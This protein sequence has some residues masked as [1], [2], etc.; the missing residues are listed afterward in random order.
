MRLRI[1]PFLG[2]LGAVFRVYLL[3]TYRRTQ[4]RAQKRL[5]TQGK[6]DRSGAPSVATL[7]LCKPKFTLYCKDERGN[8]INVR[9][10]GNTTLHQ[11]EEGKYIQVKK[12]TD[13]TGEKGYWSEGVLDN[14][15]YG[16]VNCYEFFVGKTFEVL[17]GV[18]G[19]YDP[20]DEGQPSKA[21]VQIML[22][23]VSDIEFAE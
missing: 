9:V 14:D 22:S 13:S 2:A 15:G 20:S 23:L 21:Q 10:D 3:P 11:T 1:W 6:I 12:S 18:V 7:Q 19:V 8:Q 17:R 4:K 5:K 16:K